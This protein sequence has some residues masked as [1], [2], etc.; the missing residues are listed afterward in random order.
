MKLFVPTP[1][2]KT[3]RYTRNTP[4]GAL[5]DRFVPSRRRTHPI[6]QLGTGGFSFFGILPWWALVGAFQPKE[7]VIEN[8][9]HYL[10]S[11]KS[12]SNLFK[13]EL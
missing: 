11:S 12:Q 5:L 4:L 8:K 3:T 9:G 1:T 7:A 10:L 2:C 13:K 6:I